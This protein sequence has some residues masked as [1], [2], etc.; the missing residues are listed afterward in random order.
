MIESYQYVHING[1]LEPR[2]Q[3][4]RDQV[5]Q[6]ILGKSTQDLTRCL[7]CKVEWDLHNGAKPGTEYWD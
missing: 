7:A 6:T 1:K 2:I 3:R 4:H 5:L